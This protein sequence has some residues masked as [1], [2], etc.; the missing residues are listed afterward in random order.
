MNSRY[1][2]DLNAKLIR[3]GD[4]DEDDEEKEEKQGDGMDVLGLKF[5]KTR[6]ILLCGEINKALAER[7]VRQLLVLEADSDEPIKVFIDSPGG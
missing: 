3:N 7:V 4:E 1:I 6:Q 5:L 2:N